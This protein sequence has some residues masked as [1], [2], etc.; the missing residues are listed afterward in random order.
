MENIPPRVARRWQSV[1]KPVAAKHNA[2]LAAEPRV[3]RRIY[4]V[5]L[6]DTL[7]DRSKLRGRLVLLSFLC[8]FS[9]ERYSRLYSVLEQPPVHLA[10]QRALPREKKV[11][12]L[13]LTRAPLHMQLH[14][15]RQRT[16][17]AIALQR[18]PTTAPVHRKT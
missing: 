11:A 10:L 17:H 16:V 7:R 1:R 18:R 4:G 14:K 12:L 6:K 9:V 5:C 13:V 2:Q 8:L 15:G 3:E